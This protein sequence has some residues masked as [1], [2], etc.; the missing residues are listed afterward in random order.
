MGDDEMK[1][2]LTFCSVI[3]PGPQAEINSLLL[4]ESIRAFGGGMANNPIRFFLPDYGKPLTEAAQE[5]LGRL[6]VWVTPFK[7][8]KERLQFFFMGQLAGLAEAEKMCEGESEVLAWMDGNTILLHEPKELLLPEGKSL[9]Y[10]PV[11]HLLLGSRYDQP[12]DAFWAEIYRTC[13][14]PPERV[15]AMKPVVEDLEMRPYINAGFMAVRPER[16]LLRAW[17]ESFLTLSQTP[18]FQAFQREDERYIIF[19]HQAVLAGVMLRH[20]E[21]EEMLDLPE[22]YNYPVHLFEQD[23]TG[24]RPRGVDDLVTFRHEGFYEEA[25]WMDKIP[26]S[27]ELKQWLAEKLAETR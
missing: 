5:R 27:D 19:M 23:A 16:G 8:E 15:F 25:D 13:E 10:R 1:Q 21:R 11:H 26:A 14:V 6:D 17:Y 22:S 12:P 2:K 9:G 7:M 3:F 4:A 20:L 18:T 24:H